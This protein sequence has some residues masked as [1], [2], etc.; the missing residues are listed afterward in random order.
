[1]LFCASPVLWLSVLLL[2]LV[3]AGQ[4]G[5]RTTSRVIIQIEAPRELLGRVMSVFNMDQGMRSL[6]SVVMGAFA[7]IFGASLGLALTAGFSLIVTTTLF[8]RLLGRK[9]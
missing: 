3:G 7:T 4:V 8:Y 2:A 6:G 5:F 1:M 9:T